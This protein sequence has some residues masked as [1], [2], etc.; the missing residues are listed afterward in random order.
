MN[1]FGL[2]IARTKSLNL[3]PVSSNR[4]GWW[5]IV[6]EPFA[7][8][9][10]RNVEWTY[11]D[12]LAHPIVF[13]CMRL[14]ASDIGK[15][16]L[17]LVRQDENGIWTVTENAAF[18][19]VLRK[20]NHYS[21]RNDH[22][23]QWLFSKL[24]TGNTYVLKGRDNRGVVNAMYVLDPCRVKTLVAVNGDVYY[25]L[26]TDQLAQI[27]T[28]SVTVPASE[29]MHDRMTAFYHPLVG[30]SPLMAAGQAAQQ[31]LKIQENSSLFFGNGSQPGGILTAPGVINTETA[32]RLQDQW[33][34]NYSGANYG[35]VAVLG[36]GLKYEAMAVKAVDAQLVEQWDVTAH[37]ICSAFGVPAFKVGVGPMPAY[38]NVE[39]LNQAYYS[40]CLQA[41][42]EKIE[43]LLDYGL[44][45][46]KPFG[47]RFDKDDLII[48]DTAARVD[49][50]SK[51]VRAG[52]SP[53]EARFRFFDLGPVAGG[54]TPFMQQQDWPLA[55]LA[56][57][58][59][60]DLTTA[61]NASRAT[62][63]VNDDEGDMADADAEKMFLTEM[64]KS[65]E[66]SV[67]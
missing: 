60:V 52:M 8:A 47:T 15:L 67:A 55:L 6:R 45:L 54:D 33:Q 2:T 9:W 35:K 25:E 13:A 16:T 17:D 40:D 50:A 63:V 23:E 26:Q 27:P 42:M 19:P 62:A 66:L 46:P 37:S 21:T 7:G 57:R 5:P 56:Q 39:A 48:M 51:A 11:E 29:L 4:G 61:P 65:L 43:A 53:N 14:I 58:D 34:A 24:R 44:E 31:G 41:H 30:L 20:P 18:S 10:Q 32:K 22:F 36:D 3:S 49:A 59:A 12:V 1:F 64:R 28:D 38:N